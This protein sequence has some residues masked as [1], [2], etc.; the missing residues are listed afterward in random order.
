[1]KKSEGLKIFIIYVFRTG[2]KILPLDVFCFLALFLP[3]PDPLAQVLGLK[4][5]NCRCS[6]MGFNLEAAFTEVLVSIVTLGDTG[7]LPLYFCNSSAAL[8]RLFT[9]CCRDSAMFLPP[10]LSSA[11][12]GTGFGP[13]LP[14]NPANTIASDHGNFIMRKLHHNAKTTS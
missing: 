10:S 3:K 7:E 5:N 6:S 9:H 14:F 11:I 12:L 4:P 2:M 1:M 13:M 8:V